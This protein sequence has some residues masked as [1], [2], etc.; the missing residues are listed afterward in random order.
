MKNKVLILILFLLP[1]ICML[2]IGCNKNDKESK[3]PLSIIKN[4][5]TFIDF[6]VKNNKVYLYCDIK[7]RNTCEVEKQFYVVGNFKDDY[8]T[9][10]FDSELTACNLNEDSTV[11]SIKG[12]SDEYFSIVFI[13]DFAEVEQKHDRNLPPMQI[14]IVD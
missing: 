10:L 11:F 9:L 6:E 1:L 8:G 14:V 12:K 3:E 5:S 7:V 4:D 13:G 2:V